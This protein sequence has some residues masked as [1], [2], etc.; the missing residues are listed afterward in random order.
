MTTRLYILRTEAARWV[1][2]EWETF[3]RIGFH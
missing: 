3:N 1:M 2:R